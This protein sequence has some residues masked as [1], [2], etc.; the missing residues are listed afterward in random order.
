M[1]VHIEK[2]PLLIIQTEPLSLKHHRAVA[3]NR[4]QIQTLLELQ[5]MEWG[6]FQMEKKTYEVI[7]VAYRLVI[8]C[9]YNENTKNNR[10]K[11]CIST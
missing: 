5:E 11:E 6:K 4:N 1:S 9:Y 2:Y 8:I 7:D 3:Q 10:K